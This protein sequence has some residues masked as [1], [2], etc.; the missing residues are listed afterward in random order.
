[1]LVLTRKKDESI[2]VNDNIEIFVI[3]IENDKVKIG[4]KAP[5]S[6]EILR[7]EVYESIQSENKE[8]AS[9]KTVDLNGLKGLF[10]K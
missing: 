9:N 4:I 2:I 6:V 8:A 10:K 3:G 5:N 7:K 1:M